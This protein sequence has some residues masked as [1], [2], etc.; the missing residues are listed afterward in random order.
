MSSRYEKIETSDSVTMWY[1]P[2]G[3]FSYKSSKVSDPSMR[4]AIIGDEAM[5]EE[6]YDYYLASQQ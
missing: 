5:K 2:T 1:H 6:A 4:A 3:S